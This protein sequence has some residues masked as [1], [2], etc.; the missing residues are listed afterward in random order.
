MN[1][2]HEFLVTMKKFGLEYYHRYYS[3]YPGIVRDNDDPEMRGRIMVELPTILGQ[4]RV[5]TS[6]CDPHLFRITGMEH[7]EFFPPYVDDVVDVWF[8]NGDL[9]YPVYKGGGYASEELPT[10]FQTN[11]PNVKGWVFASGQKIL[12]DETD[13]AQ[14]IRVINSD[15][16]QIVLDAGT[17]ALYLIHQAGSN[18]VMSTDGSIK[19]FGSD[20]T[21]IFLDASNGLIS[22][23]GSAGGL[24]STSA[25]PVL[26]DK[27]GNQTVSVTDT[28]VQINA[29]TDVLLSGGSSVQANCGS[30]SVSAKGGIS[31]TNSIATIEATL[32]GEVNVKAP[33]VNVGMS[34]AFG[35]GLGQNIESRLA[36][37][38][39]AMEIL[40]SV[41]G[42]AHIHPTT[43]P[44]APTGPPIPIASPFIAVPLP[45]GSV[46]CMVAI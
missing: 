25:T 1:L 26:S 33:L 20:G 10:D 36:A 22:M 24:F 37:L 23:V 7:G 16:T 40:T 15:N 3:M 41:F 4:G 44:G 17:D 14:Q 19:L 11:Y 34:P 38:E 21:Y 9:N 27:S 32:A 2:F 43:A 39:M 30:F 42:A 45:V 18:I 29:S 6:W 12:I 13:G 31:L 35:I 5:H 46:T 8:E 28:D